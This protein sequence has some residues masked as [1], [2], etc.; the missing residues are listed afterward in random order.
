MSDA[1]NPRYIAGNPPTSALL[2]LAESQGGHVN[3]PQLL[4]LGY[5]AR[6]IEYLVRRGFL[7]RVYSNVY[8]VGRHSTN[9]L[10]RAHAALLVIPERSALAGWSAGSLWG[11]RREWQYPLE[12]ITPLNRRPSGLIVHRSTAL[13][14]RDITVQHGLTTISPALTILHIAPTRTR[15]QLE[16][17]ID[18]LRLAG[19]LKMKMS[20]LHDVLARFPRHP[21]AA[22]LRQA[23]RI[24]H[25]QPTRSTWE[26]DWRPFAAT[27]DLP[28]HVMNVVLG[29]HLKRPDLPHCR[30]DVLF[31]PARLIVELDGWG[32]HDTPWAFEEDRERDFEVF[33]ELD[34]PTIRITK[35]HLQANPERQAQRILK[36]LERR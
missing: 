1:R 11:A 31:L 29:E 35:R 3:R 27:Y 14:R 10:D 33:A 34:I 18:E 4:A 13:L 6:Q 12:I 28:A 20:E 21:G 24:A 17:A 32:T 22:P 25:K 30:P 7:L 36:I 19:Y 26:Q 2:A 16:R 8:A 5:S 23:L 9:P 15:K